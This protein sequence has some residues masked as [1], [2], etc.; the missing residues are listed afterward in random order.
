MSTQ[1]FFET[2]TNPERYFGTHCQECGVFHWRLKTTRKKN[3]IAFLCDRECYIKYQTGKSFAE[4][5]SS[6]SLARRKK[7]K[8]YVDYLREGN[9]RNPND[10]QIDVMA[11]ERLRRARSTSMFA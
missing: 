11:Q 1:V 2:P 7:A 3:Q 5:L 8:R 6:E 10:I 4:R 9:K